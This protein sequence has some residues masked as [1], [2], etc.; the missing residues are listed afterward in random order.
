MPR[1]KADKNV[2]KAEKEKQEPAEVK[3]KGKGS[4]KFQHNEKLNKPSR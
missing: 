4:G 3:E 2:S 1:V